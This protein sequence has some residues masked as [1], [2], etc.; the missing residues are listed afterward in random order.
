MGAIYLEKP[1]QSDSEVISS[2]QSKHMIMHV[3]YDEIRVDHIIKHSM[4][5]FRKNAGS[6]CGRL[7]DK[8]K[9]FHGFFTKPLKKGDSLRMTYIPDKGMEVVI[10]GEYK[11]IIEGHDFM[12]AVALNWLGPH[13]PSKSFKREILGY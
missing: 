2:E 9:C 8:I 1:S 6:A 13:P 3:L 11:G 7:K 5:G 12:E 10:Q 4:N